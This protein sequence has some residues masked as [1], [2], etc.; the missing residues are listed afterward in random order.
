L[1]KLCTNACVLVYV[2]HFYSFCDVYF[3]ERFFSL[4]IFVLQLQ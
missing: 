2:L 1:F 4:E 3:M